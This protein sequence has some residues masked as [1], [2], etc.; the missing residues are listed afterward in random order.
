MIKQK[1]EAV[2][3]FTKE[4]FTVEDLIGEESG[5]YGNHNFS[6][7]FN[8]DNDMTDPE[9]LEVDLTGL[10]EENFNL[11]KDKEYTLYFLDYSD[12]WLGDFFYDGHDPLFDNIGSLIEEIKKSDKSTILVKIKV[13][14]IDDEF[15]DDDECGEIKVNLEIIK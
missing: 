11:V 8:E 12:R 3:T 2:L 5:V 9:N 13:S 10:S 1:H 4:R 15:G 14:F 7:Y 6:F